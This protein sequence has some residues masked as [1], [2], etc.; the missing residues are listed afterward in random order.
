MIELTAGCFESLCAE[1]P[2]SEQI[3]ALEDNRRA[4]LRKFWVYLAVALV[5]APLCVYTCVKEDWPTLGVM[6][7]VALFLIPIALGM[8]ALSSAGE[9]L[10][11]PVLE[12]IAARAGLEYIPSDF[13]PPAYPDARRVLFGGHLSSEDFSDLFHGTDEEGRGC[14]LYEATLKRRSGKNTH[15]VFSG[16]IYALQRRPGATGE[17]AIVPDKKLFNF[18]KPASGMERVKLE[19]EEFERRFEVY[20]TA[21]MEAKTLLMDLE[22]RRLLL[23]LRGGGR[24]MAYLDPDNALIAVR[25]NNRFE[26]G[27]MFRHTPAR[28]RVRAMLDDVCA[29][30]A[31]LRRLKA[32]LG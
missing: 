19:D 1:Q 25:G 16:Q 10:K 30:L 22:L 8:A 11:K 17:T 14:A 31:T 13:S 32:K 21:P 3:G 26:A 18:I 23:D 6:L 5:V 28:E 7:G 24:V 2:V 29:A 15:T 9:S 27:S 12:R 20:S 4:A